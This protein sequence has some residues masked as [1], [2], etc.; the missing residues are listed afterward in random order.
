MDQL[1]HDVR[2]TNWLNIIT[3]CQQ[4]PADVTANNGLQTM[5]SKKK[6]IIIGSVSFVGKLV[7]K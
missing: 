7:N 6:L 5:A 3:E 1:T 2:R 4:R